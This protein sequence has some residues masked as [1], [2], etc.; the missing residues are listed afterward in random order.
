MPSKTVLPVIFVCKDVSVASISTENCLEWLSVHSIKRWFATIGQRIS[1]E[2]FLCAPRS[3]VRKM[4]LTQPFHHGARNDPNRPA[5]RA[6]PKASS[7][8]TQEDAREERTLN[9]GSI[10]R[11][12]TRTRFDGIPDE[13]NGG[14]QDCVQGRNWPAISRAARRLAAARRNAP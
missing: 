6:C 5:C 13:A 4:S 1:N 7:R 8:P 14:G 9:S 12:Q 3:V 2:S 11:G 10:S